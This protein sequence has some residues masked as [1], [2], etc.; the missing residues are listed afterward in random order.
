MSHL[1]QVADVL[2]R[3]P[4]WDAR[5]ASWREIAGGLTNRSWLVTAGDRRY[6]L[7]LDA[8][9]AKALGLD[10]HTELA[11]HRNAAAAGLAPPIVHADPDAGVLV[12]E[13]LPGAVWDSAALADPAGMEALG[14][15][16]RAVHA[17][18]RS[19]VSF[20]APAI[21]HRYRAALDAGSARRVDADACV[22]AVERAPRRTDYACCHNDIVASN[23][24]GAESLKLLDWEYACDNDPFYDLAALVGYHRLDRATTDALLA[25]WTGRPA[26]ESRDRLDARL[27]EYAAL[28]RLWFAVMGIE[29]A[30]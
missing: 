29:K 3:I 30:R 23:I 2:E 24:V 9:P 11:V 12:Y 6:V 21:A 18:P 25:A 8:G 1:L 19:G 15:L 14:A 20:D 16:L 22:R 27:A 13:Y 10:R 4:G 7:R 28:E 26:G 17:L 5:D